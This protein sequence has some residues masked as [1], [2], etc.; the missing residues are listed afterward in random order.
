MSKKQKLKTLSGEDDIVNSFGCSASEYL[1][2]M[3]VALGLKV[4]V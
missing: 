4:S 2:G 3:T 1:L